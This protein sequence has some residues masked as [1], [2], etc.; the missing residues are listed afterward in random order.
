MVFDKML[1]SFSC[2][3]AFLNFVEDDDGAALME[4]NIVNCLQS[5]ED[6]IE[7][8]EVVKK[9]LYL[10]CGCG[11]VDEYICFILVASEFFYYC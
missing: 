7:I 6:I 11:E 4:D 2:G 9:R 1:Y 5:Q 8:H 10:L 3:W